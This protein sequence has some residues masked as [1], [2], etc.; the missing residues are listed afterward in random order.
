MNALSNGFTG[1]LEIH[2]DTQV[3]ELDR[4]KTLN[5]VEGR[6]NAAVTALL[7][8]ILFFPTTATSPCLFVKVGHIYIII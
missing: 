7:Y 1:K 5:M 8:F 6:M 3:P 2:F 4:P